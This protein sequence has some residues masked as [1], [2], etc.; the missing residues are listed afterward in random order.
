MKSLDARNTI[1]SGNYKFSLNNV[2]NFRATRV[3]YINLTMQQPKIYADKR[4]IELGLSQF[5]ALLSLFAFISSFVLA[6][7]SEDSSYSLFSILF[8]TFFLSA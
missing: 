8:E 2:T 6:F 4:S 7:F 5:A 3:N 1:Q